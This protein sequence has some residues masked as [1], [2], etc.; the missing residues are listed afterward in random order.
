MGVRLYGT[1]LRIQPNLPDAWRSARTKIIF[2]GQ[3]MELFVD[4]ET[5]TVKRLAGDGEIRFLCNGMTYTVQD[6][7]TIPYQAS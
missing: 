4:H 3:K 1:S 7:V 5:L 2:G 6:T